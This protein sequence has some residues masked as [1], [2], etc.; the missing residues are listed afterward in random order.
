M[1][2]GYVQ[3]SEVQARNAKKI[4]IFTEAL[5]IFII[6]C[7]IGALVECIFCIVIH[8]KMELRQGTIYGPFNLVYGFGALVMTFTAVPAYKRHGILAA[9]LVSALSGGALEY[10]CSLLQEVFFQTRSWNFSD[11]AFNFSGRTSLLFMLFWGVLG[12]VFAKA[13]HPFIL[14]KIANRPFMKSRALTVLMTVFMMANMS[15][16]AM[17]VTRWVDRKNGYPPQHGLD[18]YI[19]SNYD[20]TFMEKIYPNMQ[21]LTKS[22]GM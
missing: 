14:S 5:W 7:L 12:T 17:A 11:L 21:V 20:D 4:K 3:T 16:S 10:L 6:G 18:N 9:F 19:D 8:G 1:T 15:I 2:S 13:I 22:N